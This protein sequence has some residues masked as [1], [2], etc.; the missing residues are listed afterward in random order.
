[1]AIP[2]LNSID[3]VKNQIL[4]AVFQNLAVAPSDPVEGQF[5]YNTADKKMFY[6]NGTTWVDTTYLLPVAS[7]TVLGGVKVGSGLAIDGNGVLSATGTEV[8][9]I[10]NLT[11]DRADAALAAAQGKALK[12]L[13]DALQTAIDGLGTAATKNTG[14]SAGN[15]PVLG[16]DGKLDNS[17]LPALALTDVYTVD[18]ESAMLALNAQQGDVAIRS[19]VNKTYILSQSPASTLSNWVEL[20]FPVSVTSVN[21][22]TGIVVLTGDDIQVKVTSSSGSVDDATLNEALNSAFALSYSLKTHIENLIVD[23]IQV[24]SGEINIS[25]NNVSTIDI[26][27]DYEG[28]RV[29]VEEF[30]TYIKSSD[31]NIEKNVEVDWE[32]VTSGEE[33]QIKI[34][35][36]NTTYTSLNYKIVYKNIEI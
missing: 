28:Y 31:S 27:S 14:T 4:N 7:A 2:Y 17:I 23:S 5:Y 29:E 6:Y 3:L 35:I 15:V 11:S 30:Q 8:D 19:D 24:K 18:S 13:I 1:M 34:Y 32:V 26:T 20:L 36:G 10:N 12:E 16:S 22:K 21:G 9:I 25:S 33:S